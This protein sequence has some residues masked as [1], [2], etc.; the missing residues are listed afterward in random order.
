MKRTG[1]FGGS[2]DPVHSGHVRYANFIC[3]KLDLDELII[4]PAKLSP[5]KKTNSVSDNDRLNMCR[6]VF[7]DKRMTV[8]D[9]EI[10]R[11][12]V[13]Y[14]VDTVR[15]LKRQRPTDGLYL[16]VGGDQ[17][18]SFDRWRCFDEILA[19]TVLV[20]VKRDDSVS[21]EELESFADSRLRR[22]GKVE[23][24]DFIPFDVSSTEIRERLEKG[25]S[26]SGLVPEE[27]EKYILRGGLYRDI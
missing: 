25:L 5:F 22:Y 18:M 4:I 14:T 7:T 24:I 9:T 10:M 6:L 11:G 8:S 13:S 19:S 27:A 21:R 15:E 26:I 17:L 16:F 1:I 20:A 2:F 3:D 23:I 12:G